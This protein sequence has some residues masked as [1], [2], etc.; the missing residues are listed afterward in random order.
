MRLTDTISLRPWL[1]RIATTAALAAVA[2]TAEV[3]SRPARELFSDQPKGLSEQIAA[4]KFIYLGET[5]GN[6]SGGLG[7]GA[8]Y[9]GL[10]KLG[11]GLNLEKLTG[12]A[13]A[14]LYANTI[15]P[16]GASISQK[17]V[18]DLNGV[19]NL[20]TYDGARLYKLWFQQVLDEGR[21]S[22]R[23]GQIA[24]DK[25]CF[26]SE[27]AALFLNNA[28][29]TFP[30]ISANLPAPIFPLSAPGFRGRWAPDEAFSVT[31][32]V[33]AGDVG[34][35]VSNPHNTHWHFRGPDGLLG[36][37]EVAYKTHP[38]AGDPS[39][40]GT[41]KLGGFYDGKSFTDQASGSARHGNYGLYAIADQWLY[42]ESS[43]DPGTPRGL[44]LFGR[45]AWAPQADRN[46]AT[47]DGE[48]GINY[49]GLFPSRSRDLTGVALA[50][51]HLGGSYVRAA[52]GVCDHELV[53]EATHLF[54]LGEH[55]ALQPDLQY[56]VHPGGLGRV[57]DAVAAGLRLT[58]AY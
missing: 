58:L 21:W 30:I 47:F 13:G 28:F 17:Y 18:G 33:F 29:G 46:V 34:T 23:L 56:V 41:F 8:V 50:L 42:R 22:L 51:T 5:F 39:L 11:V 54:V 53:L 7:Q 38:A 27:G 26:V 52:G 37:L 4:W 32:M 45:V 44:S 12:W 36:L 25:E 19:S 40:P 57:R 16:H 15:L 48:T 24:A 6:V 14:S 55:L 43:G 1:I 31:G 10:A 9:N 2:E 20:D 35:A 49:T 3:P